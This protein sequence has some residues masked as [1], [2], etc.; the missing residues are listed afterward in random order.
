M[1]PAAGCCPGAAA[2]RADKRAEECGRGAIG[3]RGEHAIATSVRR[4]GLVHRYGGQRGGVGVHPASVR[5]RV[6]GPAERRSAR[7]DPC[8]AGLG[9]GQR[10]DQ[11]H[12]NAAFAHRD[13]A[14]RACYGSGDDRYRYHGLVSHAGRHGRERVRVDTWRVHGGVYRATVSASAGRGPCAARIRTGKR[15]EKPCGRTIGTEVEGAIRARV[16]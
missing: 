5:G 9:T 8:T 3:A 16:R 14:I 15:G 6:I 7:A 11:S 2:I 1:R 13:R 10:T 4:A 12:G